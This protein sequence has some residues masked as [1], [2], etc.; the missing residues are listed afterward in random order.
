[1]HDG[2]HSLE[3]ANDRDK[4]SDL[5]TNNVEISGH[6]L[7]CGGEGRAMAVELSKCSVN[8]R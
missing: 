8:G 3:R 1:M 5:H 2:G 6:G 4:I 7:D